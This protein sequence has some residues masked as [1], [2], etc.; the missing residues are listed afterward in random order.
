MI[1]PARTIGLNYV[2]RARETLSRLAK[3]SS[4]FLLFVAAALGALAIDPE[5]QNNQHS[6]RAEGDALIPSGGVRTRIAFADDTTRVCP[7]AGPKGPWDY[8]RMR[9]LPHGDCSTAEACT[10]WT[11]ESCPGT[12]YPGPA[13]KWR[14]VCTSGTWRCDEQER[15]KAA[16]VAR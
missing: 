8:Y 2:A 16:C 7:I 6:L 5:P 4:L 1:P 13:I 15:T 9:D 11:K 12:D 3:P 14:C 10:L